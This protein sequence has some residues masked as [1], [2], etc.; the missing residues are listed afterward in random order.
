MTKASLIHVSILIASAAA[1]ASGSPS[2]FPR[3]DSI[4]VAA[5]PI[6]VALGDMNGDGHLDV[7]AASARGRALSVALGHA[8]GSFAAP[9]MTPLDAEIHLVALA[10]LDR[11]GRLDVV[12]TGHGIAGVSCW[13]S[14]GHGKLALV[15]GAPFVAHGGEPH[16][17]GLM[18]GDVSGDGVPDVLTANQKDRSLS[19]LLGDGHGALTPALGS[20]LPL[21]GEPYM[22]AL[23]DIDGDGALD[24]VVP[25][26]SAGAVQVLR[27]DGTGRFT[28]E[29]P[30]STLARPYAI[31]VGDFD[32]DGRPDILAAHD[33]TDRVTLLLGTNESSFAPAPSSPI[34]LGSRTWALT[35][36]DFDGNGETDLAGGAG[37]RILVALRGKGADLAAAEHVSLTPTKE[38]WSVAAADLDRD[39]RDDL[40]APDA[41]ADLV[42]VWL[43]ARKAR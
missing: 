34:T 3:T 8:D 27:G 19:I 40:V 4:H 33:D 42:R 23:A 15:P 21:G 7:V 14:D 20:P 22:S 11:D 9:V 35:A 6:S 25:L 2:L 36:G 24:V 39:G 37:D 28:P 13:L 16:N 43:S 18:V 41:E 26:I 29:A 5:Q 38:S 32:G 1:C 10:D 17:H 12:A 31:T 30:I